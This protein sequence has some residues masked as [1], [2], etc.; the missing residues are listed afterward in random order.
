MAQPYVAAKQGADRDMTLVRVFKPTQT[1]RARD[2]DGGMTLKIP[3]N[4][5]QMIVG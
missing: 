2:V 5:I 3:F 4:P 1:V